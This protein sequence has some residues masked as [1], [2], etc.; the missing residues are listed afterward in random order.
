M[1]ETTKEKLFQSG[2]VKEDI[3]GYARKLSALG[4]VWSALSWHE[5]GEHG[6]SQ[7]L[8]RCGEILGEI[9]MDYSK[10][11]EILFD[12]VRCSMIDLDKNV[13]F[14]LAHFQEELDWLQKDG[15]N[16]PASLYLIDYQLEQIEAFIHAALP[17]FDLKSGYEEVK[18]IYLARQK[19]A[20][21]TV[22][23]AAGA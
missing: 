13:V 1:E 10:A 3:L 21:A 11:I 12:D 5:N 6:G 18:K 9:V 22:P 16:H 19:K 17:A 8:E 7:A 20:P 2:D 23:A 14:P 4:E 15:D